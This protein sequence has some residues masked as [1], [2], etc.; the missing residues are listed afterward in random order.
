V[1]KIFFI[2]MALLVCTAC[3]QE[4]ASDRVQS[5]LSDVEKVQRD[6]TKF[7]AYEHSLSVETSEG[8]LG[9]SYQRTLAACNSDKENN[10]T[11]L[12]SKISS[13]KNISAFIHLRI[14]PNGVKKIAE[15]AS[16]K[17]SIINESTHIEDLAKPI[18]D[19]ERRLNMLESHRD[20]L[21]ALQEKASN[22]IE[23]LI[24]ISEELSKVQ[25]ELENDK[26]Q[27]SHLLQRVNM[28]IVKINFA[29]EA[30]KSFWKPISQSFSNFSVNLSKGIADTIR[31]VAYFLPWSIVTILF[32]F[33]I[34]FLWRRGKK[35]QNST[36]T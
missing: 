2:F 8:E 28:D 23:S 35:N 31:G 22:N 29:V 15:T 25:A 30:N 18:I 4:Q 24:K 16:Q 34:R 5:T 26:G 11:I 36:T 10:C 27:N 19:N 21:L 7:L 33:F 32:I 17:G 13:G 3:S 1:K 9:H 12:D 6:S 20:R 14:K